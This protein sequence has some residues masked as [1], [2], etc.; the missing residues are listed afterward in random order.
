MNNVVTLGDKNRKDLHVRSTS[1]LKP[2]RI[3]NVVTDS[4][5]FKVILVGFNLKPKPTKYTVFHLG[6]KIN[7]TYAE[8]ESCSMAEIHVKI[9]WYFSLMWCSFKNKPVHSSISLIRRKIPSTLYVFLPIFFA[10]QKCGEL[11][12]IFDLYH[13][14]RD[15]EFGCI[16]RTLG[17]RIYDNR[18]AWANV[19][20]L[21]IIIQPRLI[22]H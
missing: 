16:K 5:K 1:D 4:T 14:K 18:D 2:G 10:G 15:T 7:C 8:C 17:V 21:F 6:F 20:F 13:I 9:S 11:C 19:G 3:A 22:D 12:S